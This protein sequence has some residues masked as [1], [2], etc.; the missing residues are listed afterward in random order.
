M[1]ALVTGGF[2]F[3]REFLRRRLSEKGW[4]VRVLDD[5]NCA[6]KTP[7]E[8]GSEFEYV[9]GDI[10]DYDTVLEAL[11]GVGVVVHLAAKHR[12]FGISEEEFYHVNVNGTRTIL[13]AMRKA[14]IGGII[15]YSSV[16]V[17]GSQ[18]L[19]TDEETIPEPDTPYGTTKLEAEKLIREWTAEQPGRKALIIRPTVVFGPRNKGNMYRLIRQIDR[20]LFVPIGDGTN[21]KSVAYVENLADA[22]MF[23]MEKGLRSVKTYSYADEPHMSFRS[24]VNCIYALF[25]RSAPIISLPVGPILAVLKPIDFAAGAVGVDFPVMLAIGK[26]NKST[27][28]TAG[29]IRHAGFKQKHSIEEG[30]AQMV[31]WYRSNKDSRPRIR[32]AGEWPTTKSQETD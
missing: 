14:E 9:V 2:G 15:F 12:F 5:A 11:K 6:A 26:M 10:C 17:Y 4:S 25:G 1:R 31:E 29:K 21:I 32:E 27:H 13:E 18:S 22:T 16:A 8:T 19:P 24:I 28:Y 7:K 23:L 3:I 30:L 20:R